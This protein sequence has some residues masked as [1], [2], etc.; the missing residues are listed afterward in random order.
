MLNFILY[1]KNQVGSGRLLVHKSVCCGSCFKSLFEKEYRNLWIVNFTVLKFSRLYVTASCRFTTSSMVF[2]L[3]FVFVFIFIDTEKISLLVLVNLADRNVNFGCVAFRFG[4]SDLIKN[5]L[6]TS[7]NEA[8]EMAGFIVQRAIHGESFT[9]SGL[10]IS[11]YAYVFAV[12]R[13]LNKFGELV[14]ERF[15]GG[16]DIED[17]FEEVVPLGEGIVGLEVFFVFFDFD[18]V[19]IDFVVQGLSV[20]VT[21]TEATVD[22]DVSFDLLKKVVGSF[23]VFK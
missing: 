10:A 19:L 15:L 4:D 14:E 1:F 2:R 16:I 12:K 22:S 20:G 7:W 9:A 5:V 18:E 8:S 21:R 23:F 13:A 3:I 11:K 17:S 6:N